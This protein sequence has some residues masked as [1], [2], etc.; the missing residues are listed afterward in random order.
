MDFTTSVYPAWVH[1]KNVPLE[2]LTQ[3]GLS[4]LASALGTPLHADQDCSKL[5]KGNSAKV[6]IA[7]DFSKQLK[8]ELVVDIDGTKVVIDVSYPWRPQCCGKCARWGH[9]EL[10]CTTRK[11]ISK[12]IPKAGPTVASVPQ[13]KSPQVPVIPVVPDVIAPLPKHSSISSPK[14]VLPAKPSKATSQ[15]ANDAPLVG[16]T[17]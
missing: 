11:T 9:H 7:I 2:L 3:K 13:A 15:L 1:L 12:W 4:Y 14:V 6:C 16:A 5:F 10:A 8:D 17:Y